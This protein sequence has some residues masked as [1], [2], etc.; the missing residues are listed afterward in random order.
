MDPSLTLESHRSQLFIK[1]KVRR[2][3]EETT[4]GLPK[5]KTKRQKR[6]Y[7]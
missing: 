6:G 4:E 2:R 1:T 3:I 5:N 7:Q